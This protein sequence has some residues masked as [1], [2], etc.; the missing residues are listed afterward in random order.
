MITITVEGRKA[1]FG[2]LVGNPDAE[3][4]SPDG[5]RVV[6]S[7]LGE[8]IRR[9][10]IR[11]ISQVYS[12]VHVWKLCIM[13][14]HIH[15]IVYVE[16]AFQGKLSLGNVVSGFKGGCSKAW[17]RLSKEGRMVG[18]PTL[19][20]LSVAGAGLNGRSSGTDANQNSILVSNRELGKDERQFSPI[21]NPAKR[22]NTRRN[23]EVRPIF[24]PDYDDRILRKKG[25]LHNWQNYLSDN[26][27]RGIIKHNNPQYFT[28][29]HNW[30][31]G[32]QKCQIVG[33]RFLLDIPDKVAVIVHRAYSDADFERYK[34]EWLA[35][36]EAGGVLVSPAISP[37]EREVMHEAMERGYCIIHLRENGFPPL[38]K[39]SGRSFDACAEGRL[40]QISP[41]EYHEYNKR[42][43]RAQCLFLN[44]LAEKI[45]GE[46]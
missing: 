41:W 1:I 16:R 40:L 43:T 28:V 20:P 22:W 35:C 2:S 6:L 45:V 31:I 11:K 9:E 18:W 46:C 42:I 27:R 3:V 8:V 29:L 24:E 19:P 34:R 10:E 38:Y 26:P 36:G 13:P 21:A 44:E 14:D 37:R 25:Q 30:N 17:L 23:P 33:N 15:L 7:P 39:P 12:F 5:P 32:S 4:G